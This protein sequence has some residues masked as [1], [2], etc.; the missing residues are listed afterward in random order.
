MKKKDLKSKMFV[1]L[2][3]GEIYLVVEDVLVKEGDFMILE[4]YSE[5]LLS[6]YRED[7]HVDIVEVF[8]I[9]NNYFKF[10]DDL[11]MMS[12]SF[13]KIE[14]NNYFVSLWKREDVLKEDVS[15][16]EQTV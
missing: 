1:K 12:L 7:K 14:L 4:I 5:D 8:K 6:N 10:K 9:N 15:D 13:D 2:R 3:N 16:N 11:G